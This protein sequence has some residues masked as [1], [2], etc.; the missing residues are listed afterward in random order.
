MKFDL[1]EQVLGSPE[2]AD[3]ENIL[4]SVSMQANV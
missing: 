3:N 1:L 2:A 4:S